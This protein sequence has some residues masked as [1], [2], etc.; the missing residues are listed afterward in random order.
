MSQGA[1]E[2]PLDDVTCKVAGA[3]LPSSRP[4]EEG[5]RAPISPMRMLNW[6]DAMYKCAW[7]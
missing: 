6:L 4:N 1:R 7:F 2:R 3:W 5:I